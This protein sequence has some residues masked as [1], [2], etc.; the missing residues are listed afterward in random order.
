METRVSLRNKTVME[1]QL[2]TSTVNLEF[3]IH[4]TCT[5][6]DCG[7]KPEERRDVTQTQGEHSIPTFQKTKKTQLKILSNSRRSSAFLLPF[8]SSLLPSPFPPPH[9][10]PFLIIRGL[11]VTPRGSAL[12]LG[13]TN[14]PRGRVWPPRTRHAV[15][16]H[17]APGTS[18][19]HCGDLPSI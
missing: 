12:S 17:P 16:H 7:R 10:P 11:A 18:A 9:H 14:L 13:A 4:L 15:P 1:T 2:R 6:L 5:C 19:E 8:S 3:H